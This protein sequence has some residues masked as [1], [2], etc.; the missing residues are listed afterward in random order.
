MGWQAGLTKARQIFFGWN[1]MAARG[2]IDKRLTAH[3]RQFVTDVTITNEAI[4][5]TFSDISPYE[6]EVPGGNRMMRSITGTLL[7]TPVQAV[8][9][10]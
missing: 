8:L 2:H 5:L 10:K 4:K 9:K 3:S 6:I 7:F 1:Q